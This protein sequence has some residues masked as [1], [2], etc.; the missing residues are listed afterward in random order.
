MNKVVCLL[1]LYNNSEEEYLFFAII[2][3]SDY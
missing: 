2:T 1:K 3:A